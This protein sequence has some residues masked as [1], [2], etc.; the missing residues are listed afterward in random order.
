MRNVNIIDIDILV[1]GNGCGERQRA[2]D[3]LNRGTILTEK[4]KIVYLAINTAD[5]V[6]TV[7]GGF[8]IVQ[9][10]VVKQ[11]VIQFEF[12]GCIGLILIE[13]GLNLSDGTV[14]GEVQ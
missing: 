2:G 13:N 12:E 5:A 7:D 1:G 8:G 11:N 3:K 6:L 9:L 4:F 10:D 14:N